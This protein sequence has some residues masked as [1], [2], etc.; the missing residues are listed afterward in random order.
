[1]WGHPVWEGLSRKDLYWLNFSNTRMSGNDWCTPSLSHLLCKL[2]SDVSRAVVTVASSGSPVGGGSG[3][4]AWGWWQDSFKG[5]PCIEKRDWLPLVC[6]VCGWALTLCQVVPAVQWVISCLLLQSARLRKTS[7]R[8]SQ[9]FF[10][11]WMRFPKGEKLRHC[12]LNFF[13][14]WKHSSSGASLHLMEAVVCLN[15]DQSIWHI[16]TNLWQQSSPHDSL[17]RRGYPMKAERNTA[18][19][20]SLSFSTSD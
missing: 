14:F 17:A 6:A 9:P 19:G 13:R 4:C 2:E 5:S 10:P 16:P 12:F 20:W 7:G 11:S 8:L 18:S 15:A 3:H 1:M